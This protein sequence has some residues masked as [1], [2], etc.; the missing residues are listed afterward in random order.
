MN[1]PLSPVQRRDLKARAHGLSPVVMIGDDGL[2]AG[3]LAEIERAI[4]THELVKIRVFS[5]DRDQRNVLLTEICTQTGAQPVQH[6]GKILVIYRQKPEEFTRIT[7]PRAAKPR[8][9]KPGVRRASS[10]DSR[11]RAGAT[12]PQREGS[13]PQRPQGSTPSRTRRTTGLAPSH[14]PRTASRVPRTR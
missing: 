7:K 1:L 4:K 10:S 12:R 3:V 9:R 2:S 8:A 5:A 14:K 6:I 11:S 13:W